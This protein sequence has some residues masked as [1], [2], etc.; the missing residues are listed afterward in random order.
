MD[1][2]AELAAP[3][4]RKGEPVPATFQARGVTPHHIVY[5]ILLDTSGLTLPQSPEVKIHLRFSKH[6]VLKEITG[7]N[8]DRELVIETP[9]R[10]RLLTREEAGTLSDRRR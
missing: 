10:V 6:F 4:E 3:A 9:E 2:F 5:E 1:A 8:D 7:S